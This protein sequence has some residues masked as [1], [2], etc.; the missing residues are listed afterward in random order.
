MCD[1]GDHIYGINHDHSVNTQVVELEQ[2]VSGDLIET[3]RVFPIPSSLS[4]TA[5]G[6]WDTDLV[7]GG[8]IKKTNS[9]RSIT[10]ELTEHQIHYYH[11]EG[12]RD[13]LIAAAELQ[14]G[15]EEV[16]RI[17]RERPDLVRRLQDIKPFQRMPEPDDDGVARYELLETVPYPRFTYRTGQ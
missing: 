11:R 15:R 13:S 3:G 6:I 1:G 2:T 5:L 17:V 7:L 10:E 8:R 16:D 12:W 14:L 4:A 9:I